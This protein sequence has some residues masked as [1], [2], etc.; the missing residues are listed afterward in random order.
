MAMAKS[1]LKEK[2]L[3]NE[4]WIEAV[5]CLAYI[6]NRCPTKAVINKTLEEAWKKKKHNIAHL[7]IFGCVAYSLVPQ[8]VRQKLDDR[9]E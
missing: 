2:H 6:L 4:Y 8:A 5:A 7:R 1:V 9:G 3:P